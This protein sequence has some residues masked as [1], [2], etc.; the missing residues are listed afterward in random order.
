MNN[1][2]DITKIKS[3]I[4]INH[5]NSVRN[6]IIAKQG[7]RDK[8][9]QYG[10]LGVAA[11]FWFS[12]QFNDTGLVLLLIPFMSLVIAL[13]HSQ[14]DLIIGGMTKWLKEEYSQ[15]LDREFGGGISH[16]DGSATNENLISNHVFSWRYYGLAVMTLGANIISFLTIIKKNEDAYYIYLLIYLTFSLLSIYIILSNSRKRKIMHL[17]Q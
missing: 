10:F 1:T 9:I 2:N 16:W 14:V 8:I 17:T 7:Q 4:I 11:I 13:L 15:E 3:E 6:D 12:F 5:Y